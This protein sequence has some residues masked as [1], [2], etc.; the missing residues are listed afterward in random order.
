LFDPETILIKLHDLLNYDNIKV[1]K[2]KKTS[3]MLLKRA[4]VSNKNEFRKLDGYLKF[5]NLD[6]KNKWKSIKAD[7]NNFERRYKKFQLDVSK[8]RSN[9]SRNEISKL[10]MATLPPHSAAKSLKSAVSNRNMVKSQLAAPTNIVINEVARTNHVIF[11][12]NLK[13]GD[14][15]W[16]LTEQDIKR[17]SV[18]ANDIDYAEYYFNR[19]NTF[20]SLKTV[21]AVD[22]K[23]K[24]TEGEQAS[25]K[26]EEIPSK[27]SK[28]SNQKSDI[29][30]DDHVSISLPS[31]TTVKSNFQ[32]QNLDSFY[33][34][35]DD[36]ED[37]E[38]FQNLILNRFVYKIKAKQLNKNKFSCHI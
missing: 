22:L 3:M 21:K 2:V 7:E 17:N 28:K 6:K 9:L 34:V 16:D 18:L 27:S 31:I 14:S 1:S 24:V 38:T 33:S 23:P 20:D 26:S 11:L 8:V 15:S 10:S 19:L 12:D 35:H 37:S 29:V 36:F 25:K 5:L 13:P 30:P 4:S 32:T